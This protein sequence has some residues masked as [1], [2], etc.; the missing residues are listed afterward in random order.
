MRKTLFSLLDLLCRTL[1]LSGSRHWTVLDPEGPQAAFL[2]E[3][4]V[5]EV[6]VVVGSDFDILIPPENINTGRKT[7]GRTITTFFA[8]NK[9]YSAL[10]Q[11]NFESLRILMVHDRSY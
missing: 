9:C 6:A 7:S 8:V 2:D 4:E 5:V 11:L 10:K 1:V 3:L